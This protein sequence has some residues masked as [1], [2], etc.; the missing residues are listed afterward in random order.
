MS[1][2]RRVAAAV[3]RAEQMAGVGGV[4]SNKG[5]LVSTVAKMLGAE[6]KM[7]RQDVQT[8]CKKLEEW[9]YLKLDKVADVAWRVRTLDGLREA[10]QFAVGEV[11]RAVTTADIEET[12]LEYLVLSWSCTWVPD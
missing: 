2:I 12:V 3:Y 4:D 5:V 6:E 1:A 11:D 10:F 9:G 7:S 8:A